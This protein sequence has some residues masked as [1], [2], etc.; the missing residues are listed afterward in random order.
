MVGVVSAELIAQAFWSRDDHGLEVV[1][2]L[3]A[4][5]N[6]AVAGN[7][8]GAH[9]LA[10]PSSAR[11]C[12][13]LTCE[14]LAGSTDCVDLVALGSVPARQSSRSIDLVD[15]FAL[16]EQVGGQARAVAA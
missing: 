10:K 9:R 7:D 6:G 2:R 11:M 14:C 4:L 12:Q 15:R 1:D 8:Q 5:E 16:G 13:M 3:C